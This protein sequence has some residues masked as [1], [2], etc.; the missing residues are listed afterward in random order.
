M[1]EVNVQSLS[2]NNATVAQVRVYLPGSV[3]VAVTGSAKKHP[4]DPS[5]RAVG[6]A[7][8]LSRAFAA[9]AAELEEY[10]METNAEHIRGQIEEKRLDRIMEVL[11]KDGIDA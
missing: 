8:A 4:K 9:A 10:A 6:E 5:V 3:E 2:D 1:S 7:L 11:F